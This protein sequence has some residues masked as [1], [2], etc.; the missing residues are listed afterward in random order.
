[1][2]NLS[3]NSAPLLP[4]HESRLMVVSLG[5]NRQDLCPLRPL[6]H[7]VI[8]VIEHLRNG[9]PQDREVRVF[10]RPDSSPLAEGSD[11]PYELRKVRMVLVLRKSNSTVRLSWI[12]MYRYPPLRMIRR[13]SKN[14]ASARSLMWV[15]TDPE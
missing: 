8:V 14:H 3:C 13:N 7:Q 6:P 11:Q 9:V 12:V 10:L 1:V 5:R 2:L 4:K 15:N